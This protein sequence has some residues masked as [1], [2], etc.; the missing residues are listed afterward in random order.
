MAF[1]L[2]S[3]RDHLPPDATIWRG[4]GTD[5]LLNLS[6]LTDDVLAPDSNFIE[7]VGRLLQAVVNLQNDINAARAAQDPPLAPVSLITKS[8]TSS[9][10]GN[11]VHNFQISIEERSLFT[12]VVD[13][14]A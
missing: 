5:W 1:D 4:D 14:A 10:R 9:P 6:Q 8:I 11:P 7:P 2:A 3:L 12:E 13:P